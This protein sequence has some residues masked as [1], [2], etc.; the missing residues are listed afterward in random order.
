MELIRVSHWRNLAG[1]AA[2]CFCLLA[3]VALLDGLVAQFQEPANLFRVL[4]GTATEINGYLP[5]GVHGVEDLTYVSSSKHLRVSFAA[6]HKGY[7][8]G[9]PMWRGM[10]ELD[11]QIE[12][13]AYRVAVGAKEASAPGRT[14]IFH[15]LVY[16]DPKSLQQ[17]SKSLIR[18]FTGL[19]PFGVAASFL[20]A[21]IL[22]VGL[23]YYLSGKREELLAQRG[24]AEIYQVIK[25]DGVYEVRFGLGNVHGIGPGV[26]VQIF[27]DQGEPVGTGQVEESSQENSLALVTTDREIK[28]GYL[29][30]R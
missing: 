10:V 25:G 22:A 7:L 6:V 18:R 5:A 29:V 20:P 21:I 15:I 30:S 3:V 2:A 1:K 8:L 9:A 26:Q 28:V 23:V 12:P 19:S 16:S 14:P 11:S 13:G 17:A 4:P 27:D 24:K